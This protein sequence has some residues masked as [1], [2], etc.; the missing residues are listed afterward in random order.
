M[1]KKSIA[2]FNYLIPT[3]KALYDILVEQKHYILPEWGGST[4][5]QAYLYNVM[6]GKVFSITEDKIKECHVLRKSTAVD[7]YDIPKGLAGHKPL[8]FDEVNLPKKEW[9]E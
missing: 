7:L 1:E 5:T 9:M 4:T 2:H 8:G 3:T 6:I